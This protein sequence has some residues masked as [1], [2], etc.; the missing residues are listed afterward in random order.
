MER[1]INVIAALCGIFFAL[2]ALAEQEQDFF[3]EDTHWVAATKKDAE[4]PNLNQGTLDYCT[5]RGGLALQVAHAL[6][7]GFAIDHINLA[8]EMPA[9]SEEQAQGREDWNEE[10]KKEVGREA[11]AMSSDP[12]WAQRVAQKVIE[13]CWKEYGERKEL[14]KPGKLHPVASSENLMTPERIIELQCEYR[15]QLAEYVVDL[16]RGGLSQDEF[17]VKYPVPP[18]WSEPMKA[19]AAT[20][21]KDAYQW[22]EASI[23]Y[24]KQVRDACMVER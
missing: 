8:F 18:D 14:K 5:A 11:A 19:V 15:R 17:W 1:F 23:D 4:K 21:V 7:E 20:V 9:V 3:P 24:G 6:E 16:A 10:L 2:S 13:R 12:D 22:K